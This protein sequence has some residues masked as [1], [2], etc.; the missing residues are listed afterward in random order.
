M[1]YTAVVSKE[2]EQSHNEESS[3]QGSLSHGASWGEEVRRAHS[4]L[5]GK[6][7]SASVS[8]P[9]K[10]SGAANDRKAD[11]THRVG[12]TPWKRKHETHLLQENPSSA[13]NY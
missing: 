13:A 11:V 7:T 10:Q 3:P 5:E 4:S 8:K 9:I 6:H 1:Y 12:T 2:T